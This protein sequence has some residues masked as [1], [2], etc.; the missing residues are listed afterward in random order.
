MPDRRMSN[1]LKEIKDE[2]ESTRKQLEAEAQKQIDDETEI[3]RK[4]IAAEVNAVTIRRAATIHSDVRRELS[5]KHNELRK[6]LLLRRD[7]L[8]NRLFDDARER[9]EEFTKSDR[10][11][12]FIIGSVKE[13]G[14]CLDLC[15][16]TVYL[17]SCDMNLAPM[18]KEL[19]DVTV[20]ADDTNDI[21]GVKILSG[22][23]SVMLNNTFGARLDAERREFR[24]RCGLTII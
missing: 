8:C 23:R 4:E 6:G 22:D 7:E 13:A 2:A 12:D 11:A 17:R 18:L 10:Y 15:T 21:G 20:E 5:Q 1:F 3:A 9:I 24:N 14:K 16:A 19:A